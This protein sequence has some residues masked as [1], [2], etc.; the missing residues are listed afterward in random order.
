MEQRYGFSTFACG[1]GAHLKL[2]QQWFDVSGCDLYSD[3]LKI[4]RERLGD[5]VPLAV[6][7]RQT[8]AECHSTKHHGQVGQWM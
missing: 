5:A 1:T 7:G 3:M 8:C 6:G 2:L 4:A